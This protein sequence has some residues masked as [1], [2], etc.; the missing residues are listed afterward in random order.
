[1][2]ASRRPELLDL[3]AV[4]ATSNEPEVRVGDVGTVVELLP[5]DGVEVEFLTP[6]GRTRHVGSLPVDDVLLL[7]H[8]S[9]ER[10][11]T[12]PINEKAIRWARRHVI[13]YGDT[14]ILPHAFE[15]KVLD[16]PAW[17]AVYDELR[18]IDFAAHARRPFK[19]YFVPKY[20]GGFRIAHRLDP[21]DVILYSAAAYEMREKVEPPGEPAERSVASSYRID[22][23][24]DGRLYAE[25]S[26]WTDY[27][28]R[29]RELAHRYDFVLETDIAEFYGRISHDGLA[30]ALRESRIPEARIESLQRFL[31]CFEAGQREGIPVGPAASHLLA[32]ACLR[33]VD[34]MLLAKGCEFARYVDDFRVFSNDRRTAVSA[35]YGLAEYLD[36]S[37]GLAVQNSKTVVRP[38]VELLQHRL[39]H[40]GRAKE[41]GKER[42][43]ARWIAELREDVGYPID[44]EEWDDD[45]RE[46]LCHELTELV[47]EAMA[48]NP[49]R[50]GTIRHALR[51]ANSLHVPTL[52]DALVDNI[53]ALSPVLRDVCKYLVSTF[54]PE[55]HRA[56]VIGDQLIDFASASD[57]APFPYVQIWI[58]HTLCERPSASTYGAVAEL[59]QKAAPELGIRPQA[60]A[61]KAFGRADWVRERKDAAMDLEP[62]DRRALIWAGQVLPPKERRAWLT[63]LEQAEDP[64]D[65]AVACHV[66]R[67]V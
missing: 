62:W 47:S 10:L 65:R 18:N 64:L 21:I 60:L 33:R 30:Q 37:Y 57:Y 28:R 24:D 36:A 7:N 63:P 9:D 46:P 32:E 19:R 16:G 45:S 54:P 67:A 53:E 51:R 14:D 55:E 48:S 12:D 41:E 2:I 44:A 39:E 35:C 1:M 34:R 43:L 25:H 58:L 11:D 4:T 59:A 66:L 52:Q 13:K 20:G 26:G 17:H 56:R 8:G 31:G 23:T 22:A 15:Y 3:V 49:I 29:S 61:A 27:V 50:F 40:P 5:P 42:R 6:D 38:T